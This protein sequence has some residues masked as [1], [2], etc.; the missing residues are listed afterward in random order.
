[1]IRFCVSCAVMTNWHELRSFTTLNQPSAERVTSMQLVC[2]ARHDQRDTLTLPFPRAPRGTP[3]WHASKYLIFHLCLV[4]H[5]RIAC[6]FIAY[7]AA[8]LSFSGL[9]LQVP[10]C[11]R[12]AN[13]LS[14]LAGAITSL[15]NGVVGNCLIGLLIGFALQRA[16]VPSYPVPLTPTRENTPG[17]GRGWCLWLRAVYLSVVRDCQRRHRLPLQS[18]RGICCR[19]VRA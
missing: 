15:S 4:Q 11:E 7:F 9:S 1:M 6:R 8:L 12:V 18:S 16:R 5:V 19:S 17:S 2:C 13:S 10:S 14:V 3:G